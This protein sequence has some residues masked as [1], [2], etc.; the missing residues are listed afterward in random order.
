MT[1]A[2]TLFSS[3]GA[4]VG[5]APE[6]SPYRD[7]RAKQAASAIAG[8]VW[9]S[10]GV[11]KVGPTNGRLFGVRYD[12]QVGT[13]A[14]ILIGLSYGRFQRYRVDPAQPVA[15]RTSG[16]EDEDIAMMEAGVSLVL[17]GRKSWHGL[18]PYVGTG[19]GVAFDVQLAEDISTYSFG[20]KGLLIPHLGVKWFPVQALAVK[21]EGR[22]YFWR[23]SYPT[24]F[25]LP[26]T[27]LD[28]PPVLTAE[29]PTAEWTM[30]PT[31]ILAVGYT[32]TF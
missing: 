24:Q 29:D 28:V 20:T 18:V 3:A 8:Y 11:A 25:F 1:L 21:L 2:V 13:A 17:T 16:P 4:Q 27:G 12:R 32:F 15:T 23:L 5:H 31:L 26:P 9:G 7:L 10:G 14:D 19:V 6:R 22:S 30:H